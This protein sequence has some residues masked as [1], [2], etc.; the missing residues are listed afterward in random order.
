[1][2]ALV[3]TAFNAVKEEFPGI[4]LLWV[5]LVINTLNEVTVLSVITS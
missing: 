4:C 2:S 1:M 3:L 5:S